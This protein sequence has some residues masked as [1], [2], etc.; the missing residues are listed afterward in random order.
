MGCHKWSNILHNRSFQGNP[1][2]GASALITESTEDVTY[3]ISLV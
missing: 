3:T 2:D 1:N